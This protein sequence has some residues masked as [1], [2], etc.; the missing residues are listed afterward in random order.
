M[1]GGEMV[2]GEITTDQLIDAFMSY[3]EKVENFTLTETQRAEW[4]P[5]LQGLTD[6]PLLVS[7]VFKGEKCDR[8]AIK[9]QIAKDAVK[10]EDAEFALTKREQYAL[11]PSNLDGLTDAELV[12]A[13]RLVRQAADKIE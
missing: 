5:G 10:L 11:E 2:T 13:F 6:D 7:Y 4:L 12:I 8:Q 1:V 3:H 9:D